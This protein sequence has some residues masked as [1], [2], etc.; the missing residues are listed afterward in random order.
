[1]GTIN[2][3]DAMIDIDLINRVSAGTQR[4]PATNLEQII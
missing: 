2:L 3:M 4:I 1:M